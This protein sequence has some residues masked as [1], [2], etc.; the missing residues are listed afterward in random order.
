MMMQIV[1]SDTS[2]SDKRLR[3]GTQPK[4]K[5]ILIMARER[6]LGLLEV[7]ESCD[8]DVLPVRDCSEARRI[9]ETQPKVQVAL[10]DTQL[11]DGDWRGVLEMVDQRH[12]NVEVVVCADRSDHRLWVDALERGA[13]D[14]LVEPYE[15][16]EVQR[17]VEG[18]AT[19][20]QIRSLAPARVMSKS[21]TAR[22]AGS[23]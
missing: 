20:S 19:R 21:N 7:L 11:P 13:Y 1:S 12:A 4:I 23:A 5:A 15:R 16:E 14:L 9:L 8:I 6:R 18:A 10:T 22:A 3:G 17:I 2:R